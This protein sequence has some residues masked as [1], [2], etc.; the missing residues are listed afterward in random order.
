MKRSVLAVLLLYICC[1]LSLTAQPTPLTGF[2]PAESAQQRNWETVYDKELQAANIDKLIRDLSARPHHI[3]S[4]GGKE[5]AEYL[6]RYFANLGFDTRIETL[7]TLFSTPKERLLEM[8]GQGGFKAT[9]SEPAL[10]ED[11]STTQYLKEQLP[12][13]NCW[14][15][16]GDV[17][18]PLVFV[19]YG[20]PEDYERLRQ[21]GIDVKGK[22]VI[23]KYGRSWRGIK[24]KV[25]QENGAVGCLIYS[26]PMDD[27]YYQG[28]VYP[29]GAFKNEFGAQ[30]GSVLDMPIYPGDPLTPGYAHTE[31]APTLE[32]NQVT[33]LLHIPVLPISYHDATPLL[34]AL[35][36]PVAPE[37]WRGAL[38]FTYHVGPSKASVHLKLS[39]L[40]ETKPLYNVIARL[41]GTT[42]PDEWIIRGNHHDAW[43]FGANDP[44]SGIAAMMEEARGIAALVKKGWKPKRTLVFCGWDGEEPGL[45]GSTE[46][47]EQYAKELQ[48]KAVIYI[49]SDGNGRGFFGAAGS[50]ALEG[51]INELAGDVMDPQTHTSIRERAHARLLTEAVST[52]TK[53]NLLS[54]PTLPVGALGSGSDYSPFFQHLGIPSLNIGFGG[55]NEGGEYHSIYDTYEH[56]RLYKDPKF[57]YGIALAQTAGK[58]MLRFCQAENLP[59]DYTSLH[60]TVAGYLNEVMAL[61]DQMRDA[62]AV[63]NQLIREG[64]YVLAADPTRVYFP[65]VAKQ[66]VPFIDFSPMQNALAGMETATRLLKEK[67]KGSASSETLNPYL[68]RAEQQLLLANGLPRRGWYRHSIYAPGYYTGYGV[69]TLPGIREALE[70][71]NWKEVGEQI[72][73]AAQAIERFSRYLEAARQSLP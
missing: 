17:T 72:I 7:Y 73:Q 26:D 15:A 53:K 71:R 55:E 18:A 14:S 51:F 57:E 10:K 56:Y 47:A 31:N 52:T 69:K 13:Y 40:W 64:K 42:Y 22:I 21:M 33:T 44:I 19:N 41:K 70:Q 30:R 25:A 5:V 48:E 66:E 58:A 61:A 20:L 1:P 34:K 46:W 23:A 3:G 16:D 29:Q 62:T 2:S 28:E 59:F 49:N 37:G 38:P 8:A 60:K 45:L 68:H 6:Q 36:G 24:P 11:P 35:E 54:Q 65:P 50:Q 27:G 63:E 39:F 9:L 67:I 32:R 4:P 12:V 43:V